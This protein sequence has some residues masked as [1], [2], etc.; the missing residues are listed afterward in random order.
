MSSPR[1]VV[2]FEHEAVLSLAIIERSS[3]PVTASLQPRPRRGSAQSRV[4][5]LGRVDEKLA[6]QVTTFKMSNTNWC[7]G[8]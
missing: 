6:K 8:S 4:A 7:C 1:R 3:P 5:L 2:S